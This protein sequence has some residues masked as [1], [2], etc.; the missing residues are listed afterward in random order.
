MRRLVLDSLM[1]LDGYFTDSQ[2]QIDWFPKFEDEDFAWSHDILT[3][4]DLLVFGRTTFEE[5]SRFFPTVDA[6]SAGWDPYIPKKLNE[7]P[8]LI[9]S[10]TMKEATWKPSIII[11]TDPAREIARLKKQPGEDIVV[12]GS[13]TIVAN[14][15]RAG[16]VD[17]FRLR[18]IPVILGSGKLLFKDQ[19]G[20]RQLKLIESKTFKSGVQALCYRPVQ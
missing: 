6:V 14:L 1:S 13:G 15:V 16:L 11:R 18:V 17:E 12:I 10:T 19:A 9:F 7:L 5:F 20:Q 3:R 2:N 4:A 8:K